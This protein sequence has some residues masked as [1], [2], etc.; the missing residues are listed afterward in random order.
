MTVKSHA[1]FEEKRTCGLENNM[2]NLADFHESP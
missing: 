2:R 1:E